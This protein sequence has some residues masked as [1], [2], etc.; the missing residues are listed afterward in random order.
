MATYENR[1]LK[2]M[3]KPSS[4]S[5]LIDFCNRTSTYF[6]YEF[7][8]VVDILWRLL[9]STANSLTNETPKTRPPYSLYHR[10]TDAL[11][12]TTIR[13]PLHHKCVSHSRRS[14]ALVL[15]V[16]LLK[17]FDEYLALE[18]VIFESFRLKSASGVREAT[19]V[20]RSF[21]NYIYPI[22]SVFNWADI[23]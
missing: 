11:D 14:I 6:G 1:N 2:H 13:F 20:N 4:Q 3:Q 8:N 5:R 21:F 15:R 22:I 7:M 23:H 10:M 12:E 17:D 18:F 16:A 19:I 9:F